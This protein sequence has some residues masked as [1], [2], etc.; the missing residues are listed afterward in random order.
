M[1]DPI[2]DVLTGIRNANIVKHGIVDVP[3]SKMELAIANILVKEGYVVKY[4]MMK[5]GGSASIRITLEHGKDKSKKIISGIKRIS[6]PS[7]RVYANKGGLPKVLGGF[8]IVIIS[9]N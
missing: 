2:A 8:G 6:K 5:D 1:G 3:P 7:L 4:D 9:T